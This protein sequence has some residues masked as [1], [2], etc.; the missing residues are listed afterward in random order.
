M[1]GYTSNINKGWVNLAQEIINQA[2]RDIQKP[3]GKDSIAKKDA[4]Y[5]L[6]SDWCSCLQ[7]MINI[8]KNPKGN[9]F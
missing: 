2:Y 7:F 5:F 3:D 8:Y 1:E 6:T 9:I 4:P